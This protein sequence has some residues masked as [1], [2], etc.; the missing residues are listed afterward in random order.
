M[1]NTP[2][3]AIFRCES[4]GKQLTTDERMGAHLIP[5]KRR[6]PIEPNGFCSKCDGSSWTISVV[7]VQGSVSIGPSIPG[8]GLAATTG[9]G[10]TQSS[11]NSNQSDYPNVPAAV[12][13]KLNEEPRSRMR[14]IAEFATAMERRNFIDQ[15]A[16]E[17]VTC[18]VLFM[19]VEAK[20]WSMQGYCSKSCLVKTEGAATEA[21]SLET[22]I[23]EATYH[24]TVRIKCISG[25]EFDVLVSFRGMLRTCPQCGAK[26]RV[27][28]VNSKK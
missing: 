7:Y 25:H 11:T 9:F 20:P 15:G 22:G 12:V 27:P 6:L 3:L 10:F 5:W 1:S 19:P 28:E 4:C 26:T 23:A 24:P 8:I 13:A 17:C 18:S 14:R 16:K 21:A 2:N